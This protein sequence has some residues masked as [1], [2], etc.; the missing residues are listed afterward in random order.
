MA[1]PPIWDA[2]D[3]PKPARWAVA[4]LVASAAFLLLALALL[5]FRAGPSWRGDPAHALGAAGAPSDLWGAEMIS[6]SQVSEDA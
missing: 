5:L 6:R 4:L 1:R 2:A 3:R